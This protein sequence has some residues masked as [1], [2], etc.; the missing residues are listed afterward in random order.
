[1]TLPGPYFFQNMIRA[2]TARAVF[3]M[4]KLSQFSKYDFA[5]T[6]FYITELSH[7]S[8]YDFARTALYIT[9]FA[10]V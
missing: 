8:K 10:G 3:C 5:R 1:M 6:V 7:F 9:K 2:V 4:T